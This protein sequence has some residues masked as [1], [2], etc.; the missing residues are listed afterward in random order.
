ME[1]KRTYESGSHKQVKVRR[2]SNKLDIGGKD[3]GESRIKARFWLD[4]QWIVAPLPE[5]R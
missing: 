2:L 4:K 1:M 5:I 3:W